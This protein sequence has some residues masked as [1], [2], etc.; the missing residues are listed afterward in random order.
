MAELLGMTG[1]I[2]RVNLTTETV[3]VIEPEEEIYRKYLGGSALG[4]YYLFKEGI[5]DPNLDPLGPDN[6]LQF[7]IGP[8][9]G[10]SPNARITLVTK[11]AYNIFCA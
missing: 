2:A 11:S 1:K 8:V 4:A 7:M 10:A 6:L 5:Y 3:T 9:T